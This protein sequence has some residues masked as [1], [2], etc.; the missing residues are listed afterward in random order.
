[1]YH[2][3]FHSSLDGHLGCFHVLAIVNCAAINIGLHVSF[4]IMI[5]SGY[6]PSSGIVGSYGSFIPSFLR[7]LHT[8]VSIVVSIV[9]KSIYTPSNSS[10]YC[11]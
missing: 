10:V 4:S 3:L 7:N 8:V 2:N 5:S 1:M 9:V 6:R 11:L